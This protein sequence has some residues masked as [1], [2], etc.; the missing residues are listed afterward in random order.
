MKT[1]EIKRDKLSQTLRPHGEVPFRVSA[2]RNLSPAFH[3]S[4]WT[5][6]PL[7]RKAQRSFYVSR[8]LNTARQ[9][10]ISGDLDLHERR[11]RNLRHSVAVLFMVFL[12]FL[13]LPNKSGPLTLNWEFCVKF[14][15]L[16]VILQYTYCH[17]T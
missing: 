13:L 17:S 4:S 7:K 2:G 12:F 10:R 9:H 1:T 3:Y 16:V 14:T 11:C 8:D 15:E 6:R 5:A